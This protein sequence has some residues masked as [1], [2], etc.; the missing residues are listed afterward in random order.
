M[1]NQCL[2]E[3]VIIFDVLSLPGNCAGNRACLS[4]ERVLSSGCGEADL[5]DFLPSGHP[6]LGFASRY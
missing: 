2:A 1:T 3:L 5:L 6:V 4:K